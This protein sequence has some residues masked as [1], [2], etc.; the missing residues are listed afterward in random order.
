MG[1]QSS[2]QIEPKFNC[3][4]T[5]WKVERIKYDLNII[6]PLEWMK[7]K[8]M[9]LFYFIQGQFQRGVDKTTSLVSATFCRRSRRNLVETNLFQL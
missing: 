7:Q 1:N 4:Y 3:G 2:S 8:L 9:K 5:K 6:S